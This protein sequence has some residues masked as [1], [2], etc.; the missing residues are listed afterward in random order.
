MLQRPGGLP[1]GAAADA[2]HM[3][4]ATVYRIDYLAT[5]NISYIANAQIRR[6]S[7]EILE[8]NG[9]RRP[10]ICTPEELFGLDPWKDDEILQEVYATREAYA[11][12]RGYDLER[13]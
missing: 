2:I 12:E 4:A 6:I 7:E 3:A 11:A 1:E 10:I 13:I 8:D 9:Y 5:R